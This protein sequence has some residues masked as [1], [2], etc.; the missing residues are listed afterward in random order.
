MRIQCKL[1]R[2]QEQIS[3]S[4]R[5]ENSNLDHRTT[6]FIEYSHSQHIQPLSRFPKSH[7]K[8]ATPQMLV[9]MLSIKLHFKLMNSTIKTHQI[10]NVLK[11]ISFYENQFVEHHSNGFRTP[12]SNS[13]FQKNWEENEN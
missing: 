1:L 10:L 13:L 2:K 7:R 4:L 6:N 12:S 9:L 11:T 8:F 5:S 3:F